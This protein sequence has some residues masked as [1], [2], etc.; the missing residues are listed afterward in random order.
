MLR[1]MINVSWQSAQFFLYCF[2]A[3]IIKYMEDIKQK[4]VYDDLLFFV[5]RL[6]CS[7]CHS[8]PSEIIRP[9]NVSPMPHNAMGVI[10]SCKISADVMTVITGL[11]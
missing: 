9:S 3:A 1:D 8:V 4:L 5:C 6:C 2:D 11:R 7:S 10:C